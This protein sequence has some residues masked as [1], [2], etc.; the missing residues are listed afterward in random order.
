MCSHDGYP[1]GRETGG[2]EQEKE[3]DP[4]SIISLNYPAGDIGYN[5]AYHPVAAPGRNGTFNLCKQLQ[6]AFNLTC[7]NDAGA[8]AELSSLTIQCTDCHN[9]EATGGTST[10]YPMTPVGPVTES[11][12]R[13]TDRTPMSQLG[14][15][16]LGPHGSARNRLL[17]GYYHTQNST[18]GMYSGY[19][20]NRIDSVTGR[21]KFELC[22]L[23]H[24][25]SA[26]T[27][28]YTNFGGS[29][30]AGWCCGTGSGGS[31]S[32]NGNLH[33]YHLGTTAVCHDCHQNVHSNVEAQNTIYGNGLGAQLPPDSH[34]NLSDG[35]VNTHLINFGPSVSGQ[36]STKPRWYFDG[37]YFRCN[38]ACHGRSMSLCWYTHTTSGQLTYWCA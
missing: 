2:T 22:F 1:D 15:Q 28:A 18:S 33:E 24:D 25:E 32:W 21:V 19:I 26:F 17:R 9:T 29:A 31:G 4:G 27:G 3:F 14:S 36:T 6:T 10:T 7:A 30:N 20:A 34:D 12:L 11:N 8:A 13:I 38:L 5:S 37:S 35:K 23:C 16:V